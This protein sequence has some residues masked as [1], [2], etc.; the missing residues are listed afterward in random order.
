MPAVQ[1]QSFLSIKMRIIYFLITFPHGVPGRRTGP[2]LDILG[3][4][5]VPLMIATIQHPDRLASAL[6][7]QFLGSVEQF[8]VRRG[9]AIDGGPVQ[10]RAV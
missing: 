10:R 4:F 1:L 8:L 5:G 9:G 3:E 7:E 2:A 6:V